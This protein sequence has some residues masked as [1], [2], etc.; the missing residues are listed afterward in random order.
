MKIKSTYSAKN[1]RE[2]SKVLE[3]LDLIEEQK[4]ASRRVK[5]VDFGEGRRA[6]YIIA[7]FPVDEK[8]K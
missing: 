8:G 7:K 5:T 3:L 2:A 1:E 6:K 4:P